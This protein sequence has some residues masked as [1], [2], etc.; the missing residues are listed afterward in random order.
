MA[1]LVRNR[2]SILLQYSRYYQVLS[3]IY[4]RAWNC[5]S[6]CIGWSNTS[7]LVQHS[8]CWLLICWL[9]IAV[10][11]IRWKQE[12]EPLSL[13]YSR[14]ATAFPITSSVCAACLTVCLL[15]PHEEITPSVAIDWNFT[16]RWCHL[17]LLQFTRNGVIF[18]TTIESIFLCDQFQRDAK[19]YCMLHS[20]IL[21]E[22]KRF[23]YII[24]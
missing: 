15:W 10:P 17:F 12:W 5:L 4:T 20:I 21:T 19:E 2:S 8:I 14:I 22:N 23:W 9:L 11:L 6:D 16:V 18:L 7:L 24:V 13:N 1:L 3:V